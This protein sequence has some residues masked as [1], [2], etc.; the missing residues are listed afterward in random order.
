MFRHIKSDSIPTKETL[1]ALTISLE[2][3]V[4]EIET[5][6]QKAGYVLSKSIAF[7]MVVKWLIEHDERKVKGESRVSYI[8]YVLHNL[9]LPLLM[10]RERG[11]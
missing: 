8:N 5:L 9:E 7:D 2:M 10:T 3:S 11:I 1:L 4:D 6:L